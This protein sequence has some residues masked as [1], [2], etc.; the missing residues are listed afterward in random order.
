MMLAASI[1]ATSIA[2]VIAA[3]VVEDAENYGVSQDQV[4]K[5]DAEKA[6]EADTKAAK[7]G[8]KSSETAEAPVAAETTE[9]NK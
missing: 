1:T 7:K 2:P 3:P 9:E 8:K 6:A 5:T 4:E